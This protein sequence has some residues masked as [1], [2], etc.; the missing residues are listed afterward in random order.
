MISPTVHVVIISWEG[1]AANALAI[2][3]ALG[4]ADCT[5]SVIY[6]NADN[7]PE[8]GAGTWYKVPQS[9]YFGRKFA[10]ALEIVAPDDVMLQI[11]ADVSYDDWPGLVRDCQASFGMFDKMGI[12]ASELSWTPWSTERV[13]DGTA[14]TEHLHNVIQSDGVV[15]ALHPQ[16]WQA[17]IGLDYGVA[18]LGWGIDWL[19][20]HLA[21]V[22]G[23]YCVRDGRHW[24]DHPKERGYSSAVATQHMKNLLAQLPVSD[25]NEILALHD[26]LQNTLKE[27]GSSP[28]P[29]STSRKNSL[30]NKKSDSV[31]SVLVW[32]SLLEGRVYLG[33][34]KP[35]ASLSLRAGDKTVGF[36]KR[37]APV[38]AT[39]VP[40][41]VLLATAPVDG[42]DVQQN[43][44]DEWQVAQWPTLR[45][46]F[47]VEGPAQSLTLGKPLELAG[48]A[49]QAMLRVALAQHR[50]KGRLRVHVTNQK[51]NATHTRDVRFKAG[52][53]G[54]NTA[55]GYQLEQIALG[56]IT[57]PTT[58][59]LEV[60]YEGSNTTTGEPPILF[61]AKPEVVVAN[62]QTPTQAQVM[63][64]GTGTDTVWYEASL[65]KEMSSGGHP[66][67]IQQGKKDILVM[68]TP[69]LQVTRIED[70]GHA[71]RFDSTGAAAAVVYINGAP[72]FATD[73]SEGPNYVHLP[74]KDL[75]GRH[76]W[77]EIRDISGSHV[78]WSDWILPRWQ[79]TPVEA[80]Q[81]E[82]KS[83]YPT[84]LFHQSPYRFAALREQLAK[85][86]PA[87]VLAQLP[88]ALD[89]LE[90][91]HDS[92]KLKPLSFPT[93][94]KPDVSIIIP[95]HNKVNVTYACLASLLLAA[96]DASFEVIL[97]DD[98]STDET[99]EI[100]K[101]V[102]GITV[103]HN[104]ESQR[105]I[106]ACNAGVSASKGRFV[107]LLNNDTE[108]TSGWLDALI[109]AFDRFDNVGLVGSKLLYPNGKLQDA[110]GI[111]W[112]TGD[113]WNYG[114]NQ[115]PW[116]PRFSYAR[117]VDYLCGAAM[118]TT[119]EI[120]DD[121]DGLSTYLEPMYFEDT[122]FAFK[123]R[124]AG[125]TTWFVPGSVVYHYE[126]MTSGTDTSSGFKRYQEVNRP[127]FKRRWT[128]AF[129][130]FTKTPSMDVVD[131]EKDRNIAGRV[132]FI[133]YTTPTPD[134]DAGSY[135]AIQ[136]IK[137][138]QSLGYKVTFLPENLA[139]FAGYT[140]E[141]NDMGVEVITAPFYTSLE[142]FIRARGREF[143]AF[144][145]T[146][147]H[148][149]NSN[150]P[151]IREVN[152]QARI[153]MNNADLH[154]LRLLRKAVA[155]KNEDQKENARI[156]Q[157]AE[158]QAMESVDLV[159]SYNDKEHAIIEAQSEGAIEVMACPW[160]LDC[161]ETIAPLKGRSGLS[162]LGGFRHH[163]NVEGV[164]WFV[165]NVMNRLEN[166]RPDIKLSIYGS[167]MPDQIKAMASD[168]IDP[169]GFVQEV[170]DAY[171]RHRVF[172][173]PLLSGAGIKGKVLAALAH[174]I[175]SVLSP[176]AA[177]GIG[178]RHGHDCMIA[179][180]ASEW[181]DGITQLNYDDALWDKLSTAGRDL[182]I[183]KFSFEA[184]RI[185]MRKALEA[186]ELFSH[187]D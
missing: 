144:Y 8:D 69:D 186:V 61:V 187:F 111:V 95:A 107:T 25:Q 141:L 135:A 157:A 51:T 137:L 17:M 179:A 82:G 175:P 164:E 113:P 134:M 149:A 63:H 93:V 121:L 155:E 98:A 28:L 143:D 160:V 56:Q 34:Q 123:V 2:A 27:P 178:L 36:E 90:A 65:T 163:P 15:W 112:G 101:I 79:L 74:L 104:A 116:D 4:D 148:V 158:F 55:G 53:E 77:M 58:I 169:A 94:K 105:F 37:A 132:L 18:N 131:L 23:R 170:S 83:P 72:A 146:R 46:I 32:A 184:G 31:S 120:W 68:E 127:K 75:S 166:T 13:C 66:L 12:W 136:E 171:D 30:M 76:S 26:R 152:P 47:G 159:L 50:A 7:A 108:V 140:K 49:G 87:E 85:G 54:G 48:S 38:D 154:Y 59:T 122:D 45:L 142:K 33:A 162:F 16:I 6:S 110:G 29:I 125:Y 22:Q 151:T 91:G 62:T 145:I 168:T 126:G 20:G 106:R 174:G 161:P 173:A 167:R 185:Q 153:I 147:Y 9:W 39:I 96:N 129:T 84:E 5:L 99:A 52:F 182:A 117:Q 138:V 165:Q 133:D 176:M 10:R 24:V 128:R 114:N 183:S 92:L 73:L 80:I 57:A 3:D 21:R 130:N 177:E 139:Y 124:D 71:F 44:L 78:F 88:I 43:G 119:R 156:V 40:L 14:L 60:V 97:V 100:E 11:Q 103:I 181:V 35:V 41:S 1:Q 19:A 172:V 150:V 42:V 180:T 64:L 115:N 67:T 81:N 70:W 86:A 118:M 89:A 102:S 109:D